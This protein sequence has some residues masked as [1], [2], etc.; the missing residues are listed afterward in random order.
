MKDNPLSS[1]RTCLVNRSN[2]SAEDKTFSTI[3]QSPR[4]RKGD[5]PQAA[6]G[7]EGGQSPGSGVTPH[8]TPLCLCVARRQVPQGARGQSWEAVLLG[9]KPRHL[10]HP[11]RLRPAFGFQRAKQLFGIVACSQRARLADDG[12][13]IA[14]CKRTEF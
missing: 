7:R 5:R 8:P 14:G 9:M 4:S 11:A 2:R 10:F 1:P 3:L 6:D 13:E 12:G